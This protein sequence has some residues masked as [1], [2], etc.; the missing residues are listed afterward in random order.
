MFPPP[1]ARGPPLLPRAVPTT[2]AA[3]T[4][5]AP[6]P[7]AALAPTP[8]AVAS[9]A[10][11]LL[12]RPLPAGWTPP[13]RRLRVLATSG[14]RGP[15]AAAAA[16]TS[17]SPPPPATLSTA[18]K[19]AT[20]GLGGILGWYCVH[21][22]N[23]L[24]VRL[25]LLGASGLPTPSLPT[26]LATTVR[27]QGVRSLYEGI[28]AG[29]FRQIFYATSRFGLFEVLRDAFS[30][31]DEAAVTPALR[32]AAGLMSGGMAAVISC[33]AEMTLVRMSNDSALPAAERRNYKS[34]FDAAATML[35]EG[36]PRVFF[37][38]V[39]PF[40][41]RAMV[42]GVCQV[43]F[44][45]WCCPRGCCGGCCCCCCCWGGAG[46]DWCARRRPPHSP[47]HRVVSRAITLTL[48]H[49]HTSRTFCL[50]S[51]SHPSPRTGGDL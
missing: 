4:P 30:G 17:T 23:T 45:C 42:V 43:G 29:T 47:S 19:F 44:P 5:R 9:G 22:F 34:V 12:R 8:T 35:R 3:R 33:P 36:G 13:A 15:P 49:A 27:E 51:K 31:G 46:G 20:A 11:A 40:A 32:L 48:T 28:G 39:V 10:A 37:S 24:A 50:L 41:Q 38:G 18:A 14:G 16:P 21:P 1:P 26:F 6:R 2:P 7:A 25:N